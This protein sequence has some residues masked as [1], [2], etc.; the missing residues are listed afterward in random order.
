M[1]HACF[2]EKKSF[3]EIR[4]ELIAMEKNGSIPTME[5]ESKEPIYFNNLWNTW[6]KK[7]PNAIAE[8]VEEKP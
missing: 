1:K 5:Y 8:V 2:K 3:K 7:N 6:K 4:E